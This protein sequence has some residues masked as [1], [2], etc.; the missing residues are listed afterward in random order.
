MPPPSAADLIKVV[1]ITLRTVAV[2][3][4][5]L[6]GLGFI[7]GAIVINV[8]PYIIIGTIFPLI[9][10]LISLFASVMDHHPGNCSALK[11][12]IIMNVLIFLGVNCFSA[13]VWVESPAYQLIAV[14]TVISLVLVIIMLILYKKTL[15]PA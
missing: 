3:G 10:C 7:V 6:Y 13:A 2:T 8:A 11:R 14:P 4:L 15:P 9:S 5:V 1:R 12:M